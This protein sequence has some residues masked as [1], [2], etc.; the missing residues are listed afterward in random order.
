MMSS[1]TGAEDGTTTGDCRLFSSEALSTVLATLTVA[2]I[3]VGVHIWGDVNNM[4]ESIK[5]LRDDNRALMSLLP[6]AAVLQQKTADLDSRLQEVR[7]DMNHLADQ[8]NSQNRTND[9][10]LQNLRRS[11]PGNDQHGE[12]TPPDKPPG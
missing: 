4:E 5:Q 6:T 1:D 11:I 10:D 8:V 2:A 3:T 7:N 12:I 9:R